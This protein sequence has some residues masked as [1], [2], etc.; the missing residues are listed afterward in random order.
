[1]RGKTRMIW[2]YAHNDYVQFLAELGIVGSLFVAGLGLYGV[3]GATIGGL[4]RHPFGLAIVMG[5]AALAAHC[6]FDFQLHNPA[7][8]TTAA[9]LFI[10]A[11]A[12]HQHE[13]A[14]MEER[15]LG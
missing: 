14:R 7:N 9:V 10:L 6:W 12:W 4:W 1:M 11:L 8:L 2:E 13:Q 15:T 5:C 3:F